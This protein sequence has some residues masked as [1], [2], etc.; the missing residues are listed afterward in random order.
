MRGTGRF[1]FLSVLGLA[2]L[3]P[4]LATDIGG[5]ELRILPGPIQPPPHH[6]SKSL[7]ILPESLKSGWVLDR[8]CHEN[9][10]PVP[11][12]QVVFGAGKVRK[13]RIT[14][15]KNIGKAWVEGDSVQLERVDA[16]ATLCLESENRVLEYDP[17]LKQYTLVSGPYMRRFL[18]GYFPM[19]VSF[20][21]EYPSQQ[22][23]L[24]DLQPPDL[25]VGAGT[26]PGRVQ[27]DTLFEGVLRIVLRFRPVHPD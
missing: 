20:N 14:R 27:V 18:D 21:L 5:S 7:V 24:V 26:P 11:A 1:I 23:R 2:G 3:S 19:R 13:L 9:L 16:N 6:H 10:D 12:M 4:A 22:L 25:R 17:L 8:Q 15:S